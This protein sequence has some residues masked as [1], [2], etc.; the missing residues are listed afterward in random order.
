MGKMDAERG[1]YTGK[2][3]PRCGLPDVSAVLSGC[4][5]PC[6]TGHRLQHSKSRSINQRSQAATVKV[7]QSIKGHRLQQ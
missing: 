3:S 5:S 1:D 7:D 4:R 6:H 2:V